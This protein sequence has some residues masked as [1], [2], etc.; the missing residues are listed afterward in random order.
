MSLSL[1]E[2]LRQAREGRGISISEVS[3]QTRISSQYLECIEN[4]DY[5]PLPGGIFNKGFVKSYARFIGFDEQEAMSDYAKLVTSNAAA[6]QELSSYRPEVLTDDQ[7]SG[8]MVPTIIFAGIILALMTGGILFLVNYLQEQTGQTRAANTAANGNRQIETA[9]IT[10]SDLPTAAEPI[11]LEF[12]SLG[13]RISVKSTIDGKVA[14]EEVQPGSVRIYIANESLKL[15]YYRG[16]ADRL[17]LTLNG[18]PI[19][20]PR[21]PA[22]GNS[23]EFEIN[24]ENLARIWSSGE[25]NPLEASPEPSLPLQPQ[26]VAT[27]TPEV[28]ETA[29]PVPS[30]SPR[31]T[32]RPTASAVATPTPSASP[33]RA[34]TPPAN[35]IRPRQTPSPTQTPQ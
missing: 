20:S 28:T 3:E 22:R 16:F 27:P 15:S 18:K 35:A 24:R 25:L 10:P 33:T 31:I 29:T 9:A 7:T 21:P 4:D 23:I 1:G 32:P 5:K 26:T 17:Q 19:A 6:E 11:R 8:S 12:K 30:P 13:E 14:S 34:A 2:K